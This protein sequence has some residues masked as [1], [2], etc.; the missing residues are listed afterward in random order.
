M[1]RVGDGELFARLI[2]LG[3]TQL[4][5]HESEVWLMPLGD[6]LDQVEIHRQFTGISRPKRE[7]F[8]DEIMPVGV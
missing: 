6:L 5:R 2:Y 7:A 3:V 1:S 8:I 4:R